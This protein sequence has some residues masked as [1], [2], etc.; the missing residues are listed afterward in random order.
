MTEK[1][2]E[3]KIINA[4]RPFFH[5][6]QEVWSLDHKSRIDFIITCKRSN[7]IF[8]LEIKKFEEKKGDEIGKIVEQCFRY[9]NCKFDINGEF[10]KVPIFLAPPLSYLFFIC[11]KEMQIIN[12]FEYFKDRHD[13]NHEHHSINGFLGNFDVGEM[14]TFMINEKQYFRFMMSNKIIW[15]N[16][17]KWGSGDIFGLHEVNYNFL[18]NKIKD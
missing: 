6:K 12:G 8:G 1:E 14:R 15:S 11:P 4:L 10:K 9:T 17:P 18:I 16:H 3:Q 7:A 2:I 5:I 13:K